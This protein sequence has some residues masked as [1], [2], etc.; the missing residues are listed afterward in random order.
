VCID[1][2]NEV[3]AFFGYYK[4]EELCDLYMSLNI[5]RAMKCSEISGSDG[6]EKMTVFWDFAPRSLVEVDRRFRGAYC[7]HHQGDE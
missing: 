4:N 2:W 6:G 3:G 7:L 1:K 5:V